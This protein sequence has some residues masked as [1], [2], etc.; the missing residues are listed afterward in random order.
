MI[1][2]EAIQRKHLQHKLHIINS[3]SGKHKLLADAKRIE[4]YMQVGGTAPTD[5]T[6]MGR[7]VG[8]AKRSVFVSNFVA[9]NLNAI[10]YYVAVCISKTTGLVIAQSPVAIAT[11]N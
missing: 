5:Y 3:L 1:H 6:T 9:A 7:S 2:V 10:V 11:V 4:I 8:D